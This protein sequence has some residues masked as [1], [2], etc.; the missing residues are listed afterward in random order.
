MLVATI[1]LAVAAVLSARAARDSARTM[2]DT[3][4]STAHS[5]ERNIKLQAVSQ[6]LNEYSSAEMGSSISTLHDSFRG[7]RAEETI[8]SFKNAWKTG[9]FSEVDT[10]VDKARRYVAWYFTK[11]YNLYKADVLKKSDIKDLTTEEQIKDILLDK[12]ERIEKPGRG[13]HMYD[14]FRDFYP[15]K[16]EGRHIEEMGA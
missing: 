6:A 9:D 10:Q 1:V 2:K 14:F 7:N 8:D 16:N 4:A 12:I 13:K 15:N 5:T 11:V 3:A